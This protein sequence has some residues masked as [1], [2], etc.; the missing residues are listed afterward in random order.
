MAQI[1]HSAQE[2]QSATWPDQMPNP[3]GR[4]ENRLLITC[5]AQGLMNVRCR[6]DI[7]GTMRR[8]FGTGLPAQPNSFTTSGERRA[9]WL[10]PDETLLMCAE[11]EDGELHRTLTTQMAGRH[12]AL[13]VISDALSVYQLQGPF[14]REVLAKGCAIDLHSTAFRPG[15]CAQSS[16]DRAAVTLICEADDIIRLTCR[17]SFADYVEAWLKDAAL[18]FGYEVR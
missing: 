10:G 8:Y 18:E 16:L 15:H 11:H 4:P 9:V 2:R 5:Q 12:F 14:V 6:E 1:K 13:T 3:D 17:R 7:T